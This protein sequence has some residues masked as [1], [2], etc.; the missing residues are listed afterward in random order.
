MMIEARL[1]EVL[2][3]GVERVVPGGVKFDF[4]SDFTLQTPGKHHERLQAPRFLH[5]RTLGI[6]L[7]ISDLDILRKRRRR[8]SIKS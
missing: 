3:S 1:S 7:C 4:P 5:L 2:K 8:Q 6:V